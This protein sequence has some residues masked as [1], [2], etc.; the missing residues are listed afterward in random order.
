MF[1]LLATLSRTGEFSAE[2]AGGLGVLHETAASPAQQSEYQ[3]VFYDKGGKAVR[4]HGFAPSF[5]TP[6]GKTDVS[7]ISLVVPMPPDTARVAVERGGQP[8][9][10]F[11]CGGVPPVISAPV[12]E[13]DSKGTLRI[14]WQATHAQGREL[15]YAVAF[16]HNGRQEPLLLAAGLQSSQWEAPAS[17]LPGTN[18]GTFYITT[19]DGCNV[20]KTKTTPIRI[21]RRAPLAR[22][23]VNRPEKSGL[24]ESST[25]LAVAWD[26]TDGVLSGNS[27][28]WYVN[29]RLA[30]TGE[31]LA[32]RP[33]S[34]SRRV[35]LVAQNSAGMRTTVEEVI[36]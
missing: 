21:A 25:V 9:D 11:V 31:V 8:L 27:L 12:V 7:G 6:D 23:R 18:A 10:A 2:Y 13:S 24:G 26:Y 32:L 16:S 34:A 35:K 14:K 15:R 22:L 5:E 3:L 33:G 20:A 1:G 36:P 30:G 4:R 17:L 19:S 29:N 28:R